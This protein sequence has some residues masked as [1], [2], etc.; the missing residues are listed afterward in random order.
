MKK[1]R[2]EV[3]AAL[4]DD[5]TYLTV[6]MFPRLG[7]PVFTAPV[8]KLTPHSD[9]NTSDPFTQ[10]LEAPGGDDQSREEAKPNHVYE[11]CSVIG[12]ASCTLQT[13]IQAS[14]LEDSKFM[15]DQLCVLGQIM[16]ALSASSPVRR[17]YLT[18]HDCHGR[19]WQKVMMTEQE[20]KSTIPKH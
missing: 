20:E 3:L 10:K 7:V 1:R 2:K 12:Q 9:R 4:E 8:Y 15:H 13:I 5:E 16:M 19:Q 17:C 14:C 18:D 11:D 6:G